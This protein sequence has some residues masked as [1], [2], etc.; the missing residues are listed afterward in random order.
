MLTS[1]SVSPVLLSWGGGLWRRLDVRSSGRLSVCPH[2]VSEADLGNPLWD[3]FHIAH[4][5]CLVGVNVPFVVC[6]KIDL[7]KWPTIAHNYLISGKPCQ[8]AR[9]LLWRVLSCHFVK[10]H[11]CNHWHRGT[12]YTAIYFLNLVNAMRV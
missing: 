4:S 3:F 11:F 9:P 8:V 7:L 5:G 1:H 12:I 10:W 6:K 2:F